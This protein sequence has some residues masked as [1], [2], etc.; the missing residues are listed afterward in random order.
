MTIARPSPIR[1]KSIKTKKSSFKIIYLGFKKGILM[2]KI[3]ENRDN[4]LE[5]DAN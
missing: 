3:T 4:Y 2:F 1:L 5:I